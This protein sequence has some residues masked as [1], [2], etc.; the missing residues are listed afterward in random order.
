MSKR[1]K[2]AWSR[3]TAD[4]NSSPLLTPEQA[5]EYLSV[6]TRTLAN[7]RCIGSPNI[8]WL[9]VGRCVRYRLSD[10]DTYLMGHTY[11]LVVSP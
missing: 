4:S 10:L 7:W 3:G 8:P 9:K 2:K 1:K 6:S 11:N 5:A